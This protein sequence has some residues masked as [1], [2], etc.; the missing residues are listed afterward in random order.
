MLAVRIPPVEK[1]PPIDERSVT[2]ISAESHLPPHKHF[3]GKQD[4]ETELTLHFLSNE[5]CGDFD[6]VQ[7]IA[8]SVNTVG[9]MK[10]RPAF[11]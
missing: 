7:L 5:I 4:T 9:R 11:K 2:D 6:R 1:H 8:T 10:D 3:K